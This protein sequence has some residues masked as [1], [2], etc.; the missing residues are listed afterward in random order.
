MTALAL[1]LDGA[2]ETGSGGDILLLP[3]VNFGLI[4]SSIV[5]CF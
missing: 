4:S 5:A 2:Y 1:R 3:F